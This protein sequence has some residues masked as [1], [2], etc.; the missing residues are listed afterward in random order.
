MMCVISWCSHNWENFLPFTSHK[1]GILGL[2]DSQYDIF[3]LQNDDSSLG[4]LKDSYQIYTVFGI[5][6]DFNT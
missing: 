5:G 2:S 3:T 6:A 4:V 1:S